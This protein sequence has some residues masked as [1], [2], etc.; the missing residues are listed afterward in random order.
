[1]L[2]SKAINFRQIFGFADEDNEISGVIIPIIQRDYAQGRASAVIIRSRFLQVLYEALAEG[3]KTTLDFIYGN[4]ENGSL[5][6]LDGQQRLTTLF[7][8]HYY[9]AQHEN[10]PEDE[11]KFMFGFS[12]ETRASSREFCKHLLGFT[13]DFNKRVL[14]EQ[15]KD[16]AWFL[17]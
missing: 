9:I 4:V 1:M 14:A 13:P 2:A 15:I 17:M 10:I 12:Y 11:W 6:P 7:L 16:E 5:I 3:R 8:L